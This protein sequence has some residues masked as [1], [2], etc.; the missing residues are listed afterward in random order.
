M[1]KIILLAGVS[2]SGKTTVG[3]LVAGRNG[4]LFYDADDFHPAENIEKMRAGQALD[5][6][7]RAG[8]LERINRFLLHKSAGGDLVLAC[9]A[10]KNTY[11]E[12]LVAGL[13]AEICWVFLL[14]T[15]ELIARRMA[16]RSGHF[17]PPALLRS[18]FDIFEK[19]ESGLLLDV[20]EPPEL[21]AKRIENHYFLNKMK[22]NFTPEF[23]LAGLGVMGK[24]LAR[25]LAGRGFRLALFNREIAGKEENVARDFLGQHPEVAAQG[26]NDLPRFVESL[27]R[28]RKILLMIPEP[29]TN[30][31]TDE[32]LPLLAPGDIVI[33]GGNA[34]YLETERRA[35]RAAARGVG[36]LGTGV[37]GG[38]QGALTGP[39][40]MV[41]GAAADYRQVKIYLENIAAK[42]PGGR[43]CCTRVGADGAGHF[44]KMT[45]N[46]IEYAEM[47]L[48]AELYGFLRDVQGLKNSE[49]ADLLETWRDPKTDSFL[50]EITV[51]ILRKTENGQSLLDLVRDE[52]SSKGTGSWAVEAAAGL[53][54]PA[55]MMAAALFARYVSAAKTERVQAA[56]LY[57]GNKPARTKMS[58][59]V[60]KK[61]YQTAR[62]INHHQG[63]GLL[64]AASEHY[65]WQLDL[66]AI[67]RIWTNGCIIR[68][69]LMNELPAC[70]RKHPALLF[71]PK[72]QRRVRAGRGALARFC[73]EAARSG[74]AAPCFL[75]ASDFLNSLAT[76]AAPANLI[77][78]QRDYFGAHTIRRTD[79][80]A[81]KSFHVNW[82]N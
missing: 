60:L 66:P 9:S 7:D 34:H 49:M 24:S 71:H 47:Q 27:P 43:V 26:F 10:L 35:A 82:K 75:A 80:P 36:W 57:P 62:I 11:R 53:G 45:H 19:P 32:L 54:F 8:W 23:G 61:A 46:G 17:M 5:D 33:D 16:A 4:M 25:N 2:G 63:F 18:Q 67:A 21:L 13:Q 15:Y 58:L 39:S 68:S 52:A 76:A 72:I 79:D 48:L 73:A 55:T 1:A 64:R 59:A 44:V 6:T 74:Q 20:S 14:G 31:F 41:G 51:D 30:V 38:E 12:Q 40:I 50:L 81:G 28:P 56:Q 37:S 78:A 42:G 77:Q 69:G 29:A 22:P 65:G 70:L 3:R